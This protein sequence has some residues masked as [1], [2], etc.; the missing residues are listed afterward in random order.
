MRNLLLFLTIVAIAGAI[1]Y[2]QTLRPPRS[3]VGPG[4]AITL[5]PGSGV[6]TLNAAEIENI[7]AQKAGQYPRAVEIVNPSGF[8]NTA[9]MKLADIIGTK[10]IMI[11]FWTY[12]CINCQRTTPY[13]NAWYKKYKDAGLEIVSIHTPEFDFEKKYDNVLA[14]VKKFEIMYPVILD[15]DYGTWSAYGNR[16]WPHKYLIDIDGYIVYDHIGEGAY[17]E[18]ERVIQKLLQEK[19]LRT[20]SATKIGSDLASPPPVDVPRAGKPGNIFWCGP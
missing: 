5:A 16:Y 2:L 13:L 1:W 9:P 18:T 3:S 12:S 4:V 15:N 7:R 19:M 11:D 6:G 17:D 14:A 10:I 20:G 8:I